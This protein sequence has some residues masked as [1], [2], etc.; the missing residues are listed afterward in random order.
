[1]EILLL[2]RY[3][4]WIICIVWVFIL[5]LISSCCKYL[6]VRSFEVR[7]IQILYL[8]LNHQAILE[9]E[10]KQMELRSKNLV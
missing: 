3:L 7:R 2:T 6:Q 4:Q 8:F 10:R 9:K 1:M 5:F